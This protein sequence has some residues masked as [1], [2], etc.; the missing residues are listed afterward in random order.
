MTSRVLPSRFFG[1]RKSVERV[2]LKDVPSIAQIDVVFT[3]KGKE[4]TSVIEVDRNALRSLISHYV[5]LLTPADILK[6]QHFDC[7]LDART[8]D[9]Q[10][11]RR[12]L[13]EDQRSALRHLAECIC[14]KKQ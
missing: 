4:Y 11:K 8:L 6:L 13:S 2:G 10:L 14:V 7:G 5:H 1:W 12:D 3:R 9:W